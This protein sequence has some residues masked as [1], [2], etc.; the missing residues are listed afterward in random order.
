MGSNPAFPL[1]MAW[2]L[3]SPMLPVWYGLSYVCAAEEKWQG[4]DLISQPCS[5]VAP[6]EQLMWPGHQQ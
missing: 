4:P 3:W 1:S 2:W 5:A 6:L